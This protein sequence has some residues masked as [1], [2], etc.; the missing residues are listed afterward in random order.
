M[1]SLENEIGLEILLRISSDRPTDLPIPNARH[2][3]GSPKP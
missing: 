2:F 1:F 3:L